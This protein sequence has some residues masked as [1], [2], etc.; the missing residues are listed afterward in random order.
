[1]KIRELFAGKT[2]AAGVQF[3]RYI[4]V[5]A[6]AAAADIGAAMLCVYAFRLSE[7]LSAAL[8][9]AVG[10]AVNYLISAAW[11]FG[12][13]RV[14]G[15]AGEIAVFTVTGLIGLGIK[16]GLISLLEKAMSGPFFAEW[17]LAPANEFV[18][19]CAATAAVTLFNFFSRKLLLYRG[20]KEGAAGK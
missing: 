3:F 13:S 20:G 10:L 15:R 14:T 7:Q 8:G 5:G 17:A 12:R 19:S 11:V 4:F 18:R 2:S 9:F 1:M 16:V 6:A